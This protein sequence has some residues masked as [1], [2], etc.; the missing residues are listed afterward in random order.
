M[1]CENYK[2]IQI[3]REFPHQTGISRKQYD[4]TLISGIEEDRRST[5]L[6]RVRINQIPL[7]K[8][9][10]IHSVVVVIYFLIEKLLFIGVR[11]FSD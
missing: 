5:S 7:F 4:V 11:L 10:R 8:S 6:V 2:R 9:T 3:C 1:F